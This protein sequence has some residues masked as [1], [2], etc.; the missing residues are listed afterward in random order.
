MNCTEYYTEVEGGQRL[1]H[2]QTII[3]LCCFALRL[4]IIALQMI[5]QLFY[6][7]KNEARLEIS[8]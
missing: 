4:E 5:T 6:V 8:L 1:E 7:F 2:H 3:H